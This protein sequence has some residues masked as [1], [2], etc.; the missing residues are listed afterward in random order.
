MPHDLRCSLSRVFS[1]KF[2]ILFFRLLQFASGKQLKDGYPL[3]FLLLFKLAT[4]RT[5]LHPF[6]RAWHQL[7]VF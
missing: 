5:W 3:F 7:Y 1:A 4:L 2:M 6:S